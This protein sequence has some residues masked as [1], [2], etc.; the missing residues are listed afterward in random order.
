MQHSLAMFLQI[1]FMTIELAEAL[2]HTYT[3]LIYSKVC[4]ARDKYL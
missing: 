4:K 2:A 3:K 1:C